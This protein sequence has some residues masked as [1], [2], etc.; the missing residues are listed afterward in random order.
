MSRIKKLTAVFV[1]VALVFT[2]QIIKRVSAANPIIIMSPQSCHGWKD[3][4]QAFTKDEQAAIGH[5]RIFGIWR[6]YSFKIPLGAMVNSVAI[7]SDAKKVDCV[8]TTTLI[9]RVSNDAGRTYGPIHKVPLTSCTDYQTD[10]TDV[11]ADFVWTPGG[12]NGA[13]LVLLVQCIGPKA[14]SDT[15]FLDWLPVQVSLF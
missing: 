3:C 11:S 13:S 2:I 8:A 14:P 4:E 5:L 1:F 15:C 12:L 9:M 10:W 7:R 6:D